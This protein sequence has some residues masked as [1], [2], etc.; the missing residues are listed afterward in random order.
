M[1]FELFWEPK[2]LV[3]KFSGVVDVLDPLAAT[4][5][6]A[7]DSRFDDLRYVIADYSAISGCN[8]GPGDMEMVGA[9]DIGGLQTNPRIQ[10]AVVTTSPEVTAMARHYR[11]VLLE[12]VPT[13]VFSTMQ[14]AR[15]WLGKG[16]NPLG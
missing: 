14:E 13:M 16:N 2:G 10:K 3:I 8:A 1:S 4:A 11:E 5:A 12:P 15:A 6:F 9:M 7:G